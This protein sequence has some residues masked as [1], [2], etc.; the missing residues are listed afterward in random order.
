MSDKTAYAQKLF[1]RAEKLKA[2][3]YS[4]FDSDWQTISNYFYPSI[5]D[6]NT[7][8]TEGLT[9][10]YDRIYD[11]APIRAATTCS[12]GVRNWVTPSTEPWLDLSPPN[13]LAKREQMNRNPRMARMAGPAAPQLDD[14]GQDDAQRWCSETATTG[15][16]E[17]TASN[18]YSVI[19]PFNRGACTFGTALMFL[20]EGK[21]TLFRFEQFKV[22][23]WVIAENDQK[24]VDTVVRWFKLTVR[25]AVQK[26]CKQMEDGSYDLSNMPKKLVQAYDKEKYDETFTFLHHVFPNEDFRQGNL[27]AEGMAFTSVYQEEQ[28]KQLVQEGGYEEMP[29]FA[30]RWARWGTDDMP[31]GTSPAYETLPEARQ[32]NYVTQFQDALAELK[33]FPRLLYPDNLDGDIQLAAGSVTTY[34]ADKPDALPKEWLT[35]G[36]SNEVIAMLERKEKALEKAFFVDIFTMLAQLDDK[37]MT[38]TEVALRNGEKLD[39]FTGTFDQYR[40][41]LINPLVLRMIGIMLRAGRLKDAPPSL[42]VQGKDPKA[43]PELAIPKIQI[44]SRVTLALNEVRNVG[45]QK[46]LEMWAPIAEQRPDIWDNINF[47][48]TFRGSGRNNGMPEVDFNPMQKVMEIRA[49][50]AKQMQAQQALEAAQGAAKAGKDLG[51]APQK[52]QDAVMG[53]MPQKAA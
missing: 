3:R 49:A 46:T 23:T 50:R 36:E 31:Y 18:F 45:V 13:N 34:Q 44:K 39:Q 4:R 24:L 30:L 12:V 29:Y 19:Q 1:K 15:L 14:N 2:D 51:K 35:G 16:Q 40:T 37:R 5:S 41:D 33:A 10:Y 22:S 27:G 8:K 43:P 26:F 38:A 6:I 20:E 7:E 21:Q 42:M 32:I 47:D 9:E 53:S 28:T 25:Q 17:L 11:S 52:M 48:E